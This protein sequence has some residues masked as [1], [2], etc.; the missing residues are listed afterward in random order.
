MPNN[1]DFM[2]IALSLARG[3]AIAGDVPVGCVVVRGGEVIGAGRNRH[4]ADNDALAHAEM[5]AIRAACGKMNSWRLHGCVLYVTL[6]PCVMCAGAIVN[7]RIKRVVFGAYDPKGGAFGG[8]FD[9]NLLGL[10]HRP[11]VIGGVSE[12]ECSEILREFFAAKRS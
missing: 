2:N 9:L 5:I 7:S 10:N 8:L 1:K 4:E 6:E 3:A 12:N 11:E